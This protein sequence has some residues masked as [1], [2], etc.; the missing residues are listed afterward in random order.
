[1]NFNLKL[2]EFTE[3]MNEFLFLLIIP[4][5]SFIQE[6]ISGL[7][8]ITTNSTIIYLIVFYSFMMLIVKI[9]SSGIE[10]KVET[11]HYALILVV[12]I[13][14]HLLSFLAYGNVSLKDFYYWD[15]NNNIYNYISAIILAPIFEELVFRGIIQQ[16]LMKETHPIIAI[17]LSAFIFTY[18]HT[19]Y[20]KGTIRYLFIGAL[21]MAVLYYITESL[22][23]TILYHC[24]H[25]AL[26]TFSE[27]ASF[28]NFLKEYFYIV[29]LISTILTIYSL[30]VYIKDKKLHPENYKSIKDI[31][32][33]L[34]RI[35]KKKAFSKSAPVM[36]TSVFSPVLNTENTDNADEVK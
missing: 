14:Y 28:H 27:K 36:K 22:K 20:S 30:K 16:K 5:I 15:S 33:N 26:I 12:F 3:R 24:L 4:L 9:Y 17:L 10:K 35:N 19:N 13:L 1:M 25:N 18:Y 11:K 23:Y 34:I 21:I 29:L 32:A 8:M 6:L 31:L 2:K 7:I